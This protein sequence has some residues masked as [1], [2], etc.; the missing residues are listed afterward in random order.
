MKN[1]HGRHKGAGY[2][3]GW[4]LKHQR[5]GQAFACIFGYHV[6]ALGQQ[7]AFVQI[8]TPE[9]SYHIPYPADQF[10]APE[11]SLGATIGENRF[12]A[13]GLELNIHTPAL[14]CTGAL[15]YGPFTKAGGDIMG[16]F[17]FLPGMECRHG[18]ISLEHSLSGSIT[19]NGKVYDFDGGCGY[20]EKDWGKSFPARYLWLSANEL[21]GEGEMVTLSVAEIPYM[22]RRFTGCICVVKI[23]GKLRRLATY[24]GA[25][26]LS[27]GPEGCVVK[28]G[29]Y[30]VRVRLPQGQG[31]QLMA[32]Y[33]GSMMRPIQESLLSPVDVCVE[34]RGNTLISRPGAMGSYEWVRA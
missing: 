5:A 1:F 12:S 21:D 22:G 2:F 9:A 13:Q 28:K 18:L 8:V 33:R 24:N 26:V 3:E 31:Q 27:W 7:G 34:K 32:P 20:I 14:T 10:S 17:R 29:R 25:R 19:L 16:P 6:D 23:G 4:Y 15:F 30:Q 11:H